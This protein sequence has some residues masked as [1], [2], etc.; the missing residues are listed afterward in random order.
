MSREH[1]VEILSVA[2]AKKYAKSVDKHFSF[3]N[4]KSLEKP[5]TLRWLTSQNPECSEKISIGLGDNFKI[6]KDNRLYIK[7]LHTVHLR[8]CGDIE[9]DYNET[10]EFMHELACSPIKSIEFCRSAS[11]HILKTINTKSIDDAVLIEMISR[12]PSKSP[13]IYD[14][15]IIEGSYSY[16]SDDLRNIVTTH[17]HAPAINR[18]LVDFACSS[19]GMSIIRHNNYATTAEQVVEIAVRTGIAD[20]VVGDAPLLTE[21]DKSVAREKIKGLF[22]IIKRSIMF[23]DIVTG[24]Y[25]FKTVNITDLKGHSSV[26]EFIKAVDTNKLALHVSVSFITEESYLS[27]KYLREAMAV[28]GENDMV[29]RFIRDSESIQ[30][31]SSRYAVIGRKLFRKEGIRKLISQRIQDIKFINKVLAEE[32]KLLSENIKEAVKNRRAV[33][34]KRNASTS[35][36]SCTIHDDIYDKE[37]ID[38]LTANVTGKL[39]VRQ[40]LRAIPCLDSDKFTLIDDV[41]IEVK[42]EV[43]NGPFNFKEFKGKHIVL[44]NID[45]KKVVPGDLSCLI[46]NLRKSIYIVG[47]TEETHGT[48][49]GVLMFC[50]Y[51]TIPDY[52]F[53]EL[54]MSMAGVEIKDGRIYPSFL[55]DARGLSLSKQDYN[56]IDI[57]IFIP[58]TCK[59]SAKWANN[60]HKLKLKI[61]KSVEEARI[62]SQ[63]LTNCLT[64]NIG[65]SDIDITSDIDN[66]VAYSKRCSLTPISACSVSFT[67]NIFMGYDELGIPLYGACGPSD[68]MREVNRTGSLGELYPELE[69]KNKMFGKITAVGRKRIRRGSHNICI[70]IRGLTKESA[71][72]RSSN[73]EL[74]KITESLVPSLEAA[75][76]F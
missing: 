2:S 13:P 47:D 4:L 24:E 69:D 72:I 39:V 10:L 25:L 34:P 42:K 75:M 63:P 18:I 23:K 70:Y 20:E 16:R 11:I 73:L 7:H 67:D 43:L 22:N 14:K 30:E 53:E 46:S 15:I 76:P 5:D 33:S 21:T 60:L 52:I 62:V 32:C 71:F 19:D 3:A 40:G 1:V 55:D 36:F 54:M 45:P 66:G 41:G 59:I 56:D 35:I 31:Q 12:I 44:G 29:S 28:V 27:S 49:E 68:G 8:I 26:D 61:Q 17:D 51:S 6:T 50:E 9:L 65:V 64:K 57:T 38:Y 37:F 48:S 74:I 58:D